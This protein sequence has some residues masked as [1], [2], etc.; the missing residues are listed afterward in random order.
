MSMVAAWL[1]SGDAARTRAAN[2]IFMAVS[3]S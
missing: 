1:T 3:L 2:T